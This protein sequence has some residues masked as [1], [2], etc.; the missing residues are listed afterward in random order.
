MRIQHVK[1]SNILGIT[2]LELTPQGYTQ[3]SGPNGTGKTS[4]L[5][6]IKA[7]LGVG[8]DATLLR[9]G[10]ERGE[11]VLVLDDGTEIR[12]AV[13]QAGARTTVKGP[14][15]KPLPKPA[16]VIQ[17]LADV[18][19]VNPVDFLLAKP[20][21]RVRVLLE[22]MPLSADVERL[23]QLSGVQV[24][25]DPGAHALTVIE[26][27]RKQVY[28]DRTGTNRAVKE[29]E[30]TISHLR[31]ALPEAPGGVEG[32]EATLQAEIDAAAAARDTTLERIRKK[33]D[34]LTA[35][36]QQKIDE[37]KAESQR[38]IDAV[39]AEL[40]EQSAKAAAAREKAI[41]AHADA[42]QPKTAALAT[43]RANRDAV[44][45]RKGTLETITKLET[46]LEALRQDAA[47]QTQALDDIDAYKV[48]LLQ[49]LP[50]PGIE[51][52]DGELYV[53]GVLLD[54][55][56]TARQVRIAVDL[57]KLRAG[58]LAV[59]CVD[60]IEAL[61]KESREALRK[62]ALEAGLQLFVTRVT[63]TGE[64]AINTAG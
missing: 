7:A 46:E 34:G 21:E 25:A 14:D 44:A 50:I 47:R 36:A 19:S 11:V 51:V 32:D 53:D 30:V 64:F 57:A 60:R 40:A 28:D 2:E 24:E 45:R 61:D 31:Q 39:K 27:V 20:K 55:V 63:D 12:K 42:T 52:R 10:A 35:E 43:L 8:E 6:A 22:S 37:I 1:I 26:E 18:L 5:E 3:I 54:R 62:G 49:S 4:V 38:Q 33:L 41:A 17:G 23:Q 48:E 13:S 59:A 16:A 9:N 29:K 58:D 56:N 15:G